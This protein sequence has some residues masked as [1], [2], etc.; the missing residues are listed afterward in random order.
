MRPI[1]E[2]TL[3]TRTEQ[4]RSRQLGVLNARR[5]LD[6]VALGIVPAAAAGLLAFAHTNR[7]YWGGVVAICILVVNQL[8]SRTRYP[9]HL[10]PVARLATCGLTP[11]L[12]ALL[13][14]AVALST[15][16][17]SLGDSL[18][19]AVVGAVPLAA[20]GCWVRDR[21]DRNV[22]ARIAVI[23][24]P[25]VAEG[26]SREIAAAKIRG[27]RVLG[28]I[29]VGGRPLTDP[30]PGVPHL[31]SIEGLRRI[32]PRPP[33][34]IARPRAGPGR[35]GL[36]PRHLRRGRRRLPRP[37]GEVDRGKPVLRGA[38][39]PRSRRPDQ[40]GLVPVHDA[41][42]L[43]AYPDRSRSGSSTSRSA[44]SRWSRSRR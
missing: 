33:D 3:D 29:S 16:M 28:W 41:P 11:F 23:G 37:P 17:G 2:P 42:A 27:Y 38:P 13:A 22:G 5:V 20:L 6:L 30:A 24:D 44:A 18:I 9:L 36:S 14:W 32:V 10:M 12:G 21:F 7:P 8:V 43:P 4:P 39:G 1:L 25:E 34:R 19:P 15:G 35:G 26:L 31:G 40:R